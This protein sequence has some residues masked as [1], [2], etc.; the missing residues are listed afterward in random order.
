MPWFIPLLMLSLLLS[1][2]P[3]AAFCFEE[4][5]ARYGVPPGLLWA[6]ASVESNFDPQAVN[7]NGNGTY[8]TGVMQINSSWEREL[9]P[10]LWHR[11]QEDPCTNV[12]VGAWVL[13]DCLQRHG[14][15][16]EGV[17]CYNARSTDKQAD[18]A[19]RVITVIDRMHRE[20]EKTPSM[21]KNR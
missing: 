2:R 21:V 3:A 13:A 17:G 6:I 8:D 5:G 15:T 9:G 19:R 18:Y 10:A 1:P 4:A 11:L 14:Y 16:W 20:A 7:T 12:Q